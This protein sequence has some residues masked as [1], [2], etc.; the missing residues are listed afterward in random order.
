VRGDG[1][2]VSAETPADVS[3]ET[4][5]VGTPAHPGTSAPSLVELMRLTREERVAFGCGRSA[6]PAAAGALSGAGYAGFKRNVALAMG[7]WLASVEEPPGEA[8]AVLMDALRDDEPL[9]R[10]HAA[11]AL[12]R[13]GCG[14][15]PSALAAALTEETGVLVRHELEGALGR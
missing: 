5:G 11:W 12:G 8:V 7:H 2:H 6:R 14:R 13:T 9:V 1:G 10:G 3:A 4:P 15:A